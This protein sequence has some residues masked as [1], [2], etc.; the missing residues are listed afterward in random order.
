MR[1]N[2]IILILAIVSVFFLAACTTLSPEQQVCPAPGASAGLAAQGGQ[3]GNVSITP[4]TEI[5]PNESQ[6]INQSATSPQNSTVAPSSGVIYLQ[7]K[8]PT[9]KVVEGKLIDFSLKAVDPD[10]DPITYTYSPPLDSTG[11]WQTR[12]GDA[13][14]YFSTITASDGKS[15]TSQQIRIIVLPANRPPVLQHIPDVTVNEGDTV[16]FEPVATDPDNDTVSFNYSGWMHS[17]T[18]TTNYNDAGEHIVRVTATDGINS[19]SQDVRV[20]VRNVDRPPVLGDMP[21]IVAKEGDLIKL[22]YYAFDPDQDKLYYTFSKPFNSQGEWQTG[23]NDAG[24]YAATVT[25]SDGQLTDT[26]AFKVTVLNT[27]RPPVISNVGNMTVKE[28]ETVSYHPIVSDPDG[29]K[30]TV[31]YSGW[32]NSSTYTTNYN[33]QGTHV[34]TV[35]ASDGIESTSV[36]STVTVINVNRPPVFQLPQ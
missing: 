33:D 25:V 24:D 3:Q 26:K 36:D 30:V 18:Y 5:T 10:G 7:D 9:M 1:G 6:I 11:M 12:V 15:S 16:K 34:V 31:F 14:T 27:D 8:I 29:D 2:G 13:G 28:G 35:T 17:S 32:M 22:N 19:V 23:Y 20:I 21:D 4:V